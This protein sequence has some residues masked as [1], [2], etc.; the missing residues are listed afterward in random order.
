MYRLSCAL[1][2]HPD[3][4]LVKLVSG[5]I[6]LVHRPL[7]TAILAIGSAREPWQMRGLSKDALALLGK[8]DR[9][10]KMS[11]SGDANQPAVLGE[12]N[13]AVAVQAAH[14]APRSQRSVIDVGAV[15]EVHAAV[16]LMAFEEALE[17]RYRRF[18]VLIARAGRIRR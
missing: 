4:L 6:T 18:V 13:A 1:R 17:F 9:A 7:W 10:G 3:V 5:K 16:L 15:Q 14:I 2:N 11:C 12:W 8:L